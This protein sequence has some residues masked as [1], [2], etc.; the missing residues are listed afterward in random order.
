ML[1][2]VFQTAPAAFLAELLLKGAAVVLAAGIAIRFARRSSASQRHTIWTVALVILALLPLGLISAPELRLRAPARAPMASGAPSPTAAHGLSAD[3]TTIATSGYADRID[4]HEPVAPSVDVTTTGA[5]F[6]RPERKATNILAGWIRL[7][8]LAV[9]GSGVLVLLF[10]SGRSRL[11]VAMITRFG[12]TPA[13]S[14]EREY[15]LDC[16]RALGMR[17][18][19]RVLVTHWTS[20][21]VTWGS[22]RP[23]LL[24]PP[25]VEFWSEER[26]RVAVRH[27]LAH[28]SRHDYVWQS[29]A[30]IAIACHWP[31]PFAWV[32]RRAM[33]QEQE[34]ACD[35][36]VLLGG[37]TSPE[38]A[39]HLVEIARTSSSPR[40]S[41]TRTASRESELGQRVSDILNSSFNRAP[42][43]AP[44]ATVG[45][46]TALL[47]GLGVAGATFA[48]APTTPGSVEEI[49]AL[50]GDR[51]PEAFEVLLAQLADA[52]PQRRGVAALSLGER[53]DPAAVQP[54]ISAVTD[55][56]P[57]VRENAA[58]ALVNFGG[59]GPTRA[60]VQLT[61]DDLPSV[62]AVAAWVL[63]QVGSA[64]AAEAL[65]RLIDAEP[66][67]HTRHMAV[68]AATRIADVDV[69]PRF[70]ERL[71][72]ADSSRRTDLAMGL[73]L[74]GDPRALS[75]LAELATTDESEQVR[76]TAVR[77]LERIDDP[78]RIDV[79][80]AA[81]S[82]SRWRVRNQ[83]L[84]QLAALEEDRA[85]QAVF[86]ALRDPEHQVRLNA[87]W[88]LDEPFR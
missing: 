41:L 39:E 11:R 46:A 4:W 78:G 66:D 73:G 61:S 23:V 5:S 63:G 64:E 15:V 44:S 55:V 79:W 47:L 56:D 59:P 1:L 2:D 14:R 85:R 82:D 12:S 32:A 18:R 88:A 52:D 29:V 76:G 19:P 10:L 45:V 51:S 28:V 16:A 21:P 40:P 49:W 34:R 81:M 42:L 37:T 72:T 54:L 67:P 6:V 43:S 30:D 62:R 27:E 71:A 8:I 36:A 87:A 57:Y 24:L 58:V 35:D 31:N 84:L 53:G 83:A 75:A 86:D 9:W 69:L 33:R 70:I 68:M 38:Y 26:M 3:E 7:S 74:S 48:A 13:E 22:L 17:R 65:F 25:G 60:V 80:L 20:V 77:A 50:T